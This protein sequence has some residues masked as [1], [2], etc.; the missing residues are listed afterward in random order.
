MRV[1][2]DLMAF[3]AFKAARYLNFFPATLLAGILLVASA[4]VQSAGSLFKNK[5]KDGVVT[6]SDAPMVRG[7]VARTSYKGT[8]RKP[9][10]SNPC[11]GMSASQ[12]DAKGRALNTEFEEVAIKFSVDP[13]L[14]KAVA[15]AESCFDPSAVSSA[16]AKGLMQLMPTTAKAMGVRNILDP[17]QN[18]LGGAQ[19]LA[20]MLARYSSD[21]HLALAAYNAGPGNVDKYNGV[22]PFNETRRY[23][24]AVKKFRQDYAPQFKP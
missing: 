4:D 18:L 24:T 20:A 6:F 23:I 1:D 22:P 14:L 8:V 19:Y 11:R 21:T 7:K 13:A 15:R 17:Q 3:S 9:T 16:G 5:D 12:L 10:G 2:I